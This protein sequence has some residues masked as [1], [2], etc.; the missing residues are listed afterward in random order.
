M[1]SAAGQGRHRDLCRASAIP[2]FRPKPGFAREWARLAKE[3]GCRY[4]VFTT[5]HHDG[6]ALHDSKVSDFDAGSVLQRDLVKEIVDALHAEGLR[7]GF[8][9]SVIDWHHDQYEYARSKQLPHPL[10][11]KPYPNGQRDHA[12]VPRT[13]FTAK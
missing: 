1:D 6:F 3:A 11:G 8:Y 10:L 13:T 4:V 5:K 9:H 12:E 7:V 2:L